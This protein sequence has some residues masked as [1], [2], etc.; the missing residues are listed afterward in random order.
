MKKKELLSRQRARNE[1][2]PYGAFIMLLF[3]TLFLNA[4]NI[5]SQEKTIT[6][7]VKD[8]AGE[9]LPGASVLE[10]GTNNGTQTD[11]DGNY[12]LSVTSDSATLVFLYIGYTNL[13]Q[14]IEGKSVLNV[15]LKED[16]ESLD[17]IVVIGY[18]TQRKTDLTGSV[19]SVAAKDIAV[20]PVP[21]FDLAIQGR[22]AGVQITSDSA[23]PG[24][25]TSI[26]IRGANSILGNNEP[27]IVLDGYPLP[28][29]TEASGDGQG[30]ST[31]TNPLSFLNPSEIASIDILKDASA[32]AIYGSRGA[33]GVIIVTTKRGSDRKP[34]ITITSETGISRIPDRFPELLDGPTYASLRNENAIVLGNEIP[35]DG[36]DTPLPEE[37]GTT[38]WLDKILRAGYRQNVQ[39]SASGGSKKTKYFLSSSYLRN[40]GIL[41]KTQYQRGNIR[42]N[43]DT[44]LSDRFSVRTSIN[45]TR[46]K[47]NRSNNGSGV[48]VASGPIFNAYKA[49]PLMSP[50]QEF[51]ED[52]DNDNIVGNPKIQLEQTSN[53]TFNENFL[54]SLQAKYKLFKGLDFNL[55]T[56]TSSKDSRREMYFPRTTRQ[57]DF[58]DGRAIY[59]ISKNQNILLETYFNYNNKLGKK[60]SHRL[61]L[62]GGYSFQ[63]NTTR[64]LN[65]RVEGFPTDA[66]GTDALALGLN[67][68]VP[69]SR[70]IKR[71]IASFYFR[72]NYNYK[73]KY[74]L[75]FSGRA[76]GASVFAAN[77]KWGFF[78]SGAVAWNVSKENFFE[79]IT[80]VVSNL[81][82]RASYGLT[83]SQSISPL[84]SLTLLG[85]ANAVINN[86]LQSGLAPSQ[87]A[88]PNLEW[89][90]TT[91]YDIGLDL[92]L[93]NGRI[94]ST[95]DYY[96][97]T[98]D[99]LLMNFPL[100]TSAGFG[101]IA[102]NA[103]SI[104]NKGYEITLG[105][106]I[107]ESDKFQ[108]NTL[109]NYS[110]NRSKIL[111]LGEDG[112]DIFGRAPGTNIVNTSSNV[113]RVGEVFGALYGYEITGLIQESD[114]DE[115]GAPLIPLNTNYG[116]RGSYKFKDADG[117]GTITPADR[118]IIGDPTPDFI[119][120]WNND[121]TYGDFSL[122]IFIQG[123]IGNDVMNIDR[124]FLASG[125]TVNNSLLSWYNN[126]YTATNQTNDVRYPSFNQQ[127]N[128]QPSSAVV[129]DGS[130]VRLKNVSLNYNVPVKDS[131]VFSKVRMYLTATNLMTFTNY[132]GVDPEV[133]IM[134]RRGF[135]QGVDFAA[136][137]RGQTVTIGLQLGF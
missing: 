51:Q 85:P 15:T 53:G 71:T 16:A 100:P 105:A 55:R 23:E 101:T 6:G 132:S 34:K 46:I 48:I 38:R 39:L 22:A 65:T 44:K 89:E 134:G 90:K 130:F 119:F 91:Q 43:L 25:S 94:F 93:L 92:S 113:M 29:G 127:S 81:K 104:E 49:N 102:S 56:G 60:K 84:R 24:G 28:E 9:P 8:E 86:Q 50:D 21:S 42:V 77:N 99:D 82:F 110:A 67:P 19:S 112:S 20:T 120:G 18:G 118:G 121:F 124:L 116:V 133:N 135:G 3:F 111:S 97:K 62:A 40:Q 11:F 76:D 125:R 137:P 115:N 52:F 88:N 17:E 58:V 10:K 122:S 30:H 64:S 41:N 123:V 12:S 98:T 83:G 74:Y 79:G 27:L 33:N 36:I 32:T 63:D 59:N 2:R 7:T 131:N 57:G 103:G 5:Y 68:F 45:Y 136:Y 107:I 37:F 14:S 69:T 128:L 114:F 73:S 75:T 109:I 87:L 72:S 1:K 129:E 126:R 35:Y 96:R 26:R 66:L 61:N 108:W 4:Q 47:N 70:K 106:H 54:I 80:P 31:P 78:P 117:N 95:V 13:E